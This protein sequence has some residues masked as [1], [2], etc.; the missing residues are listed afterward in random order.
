V[1]LLPMQ[2]VGALTSLRKTAFSLLISVSFLNQNVLN[3]NNCSLFLYPRFVV[4]CILL[5]F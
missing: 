4:N 2:S 3:Q 1:F 5:R